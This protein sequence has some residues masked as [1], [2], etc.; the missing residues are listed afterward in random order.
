M[1]RGEEMLFPP[2]ERG[3][4]GKKG[5]GVDCWGPLHRSTQS[6]SENWDQLEIPEPRVGGRAGEVDLDL[7]FPF[8]FL[9]SLSGR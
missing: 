2:G 3:G 7:S 5:D 1:S 9:H 8:F 4:G 6:G